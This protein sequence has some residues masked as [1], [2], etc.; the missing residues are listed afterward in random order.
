MLLH[1]FGVLVHDLLESGLHVR[2]RASGR[3]MAPAVRDGDVM[4]VAPVDPAQVA[5]GEVILCDTWRGPLAHRV[6]AV[7]RRGDER[8]LV[9]R[10]D[11]SLED[12]APVDARQVRGRLVL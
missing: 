6:V 2:F 4:T 12:D 7:D 9:L 11:C 10:G 8:R 1:A 5:V 3:S